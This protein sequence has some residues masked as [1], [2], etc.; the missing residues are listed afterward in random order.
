MAPYRTR[1]PRGVARRGPR[2]TQGHRLRAKTLR[3]NSSKNSTKRARCKNQWLIVTKAHKR[4]CG[5]IYT[6]RARRASDTYIDW[7]DE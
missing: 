7:R 3:Q 4:T 1:S 5:G 2:K 6:A